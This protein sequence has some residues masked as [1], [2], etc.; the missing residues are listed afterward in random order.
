MNFLEIKA[1]GN[2]FMKTNLQSII[3]LM[4]LAF[5]TDLTSHLNVLNLTLQDRK[6]KYIYYICFI[7]FGKNWKYFKIY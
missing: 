7:V 5:L 2:N 6:Q 3:F 1:L 4:S